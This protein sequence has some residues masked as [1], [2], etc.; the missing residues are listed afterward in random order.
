MLSGAAALLAPFVITYSGKEMSV[1]AKIR[2]I[3]VWV[4][5]AVG[6]QYKFTATVHFADGDADLG[7]REIGFETRDDP[8]TEE[9][10]A[11]VVKGLA[12]AILRARNELQAASNASRVIPAIQKG[13]E[14]FL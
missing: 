3:N 4:G 11:V 7:Q 9:G 6:T 5:M 1:V 8:E 10:R 14:K 13:I 2:V 12:K